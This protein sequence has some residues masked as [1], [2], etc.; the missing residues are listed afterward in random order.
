MTVFRHP[1]KNDDPYAA[2]RAANEELEQAL[3]AA[4]HAL[5]SYQYGNASPDLAEEIADDI[6]AL[7]F[8]R[9]RTRAVL[10]PLPAPP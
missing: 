5:R 4:F 8:R 7:L 6:E 10:E 2:D 1:V 3:S 9:H